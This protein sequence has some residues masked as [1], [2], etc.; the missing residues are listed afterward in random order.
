MGKEYRFEYAW[1]NAYINEKENGE[2]VLTVYS[3]VP[4]GEMVYTRKYSSVK[5]AKMAM[6]KICEVD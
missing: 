6:A 1:C 4:D 5:S 3:K 2:A